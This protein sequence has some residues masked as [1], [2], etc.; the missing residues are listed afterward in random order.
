MPPPCSDTNRWPYP[1]PPPCSDTNFWPYPMPPPMF[2]HQ[3]LALPHATSMFRHQL[4]ALPHA[5]SMFR[6]QLLALPHATS[7]FRHQLLALP[8]ATSMFPGVCTFLK[9]L[10][11]QTVSTCT[12]EQSHS[13]P[14][15]MKAAL[16]SSL[17]T[18]GV[19]GPPWHPCRHHCHCWWFPPPPPLKMPWNGGTCWWIECVDVLSGQS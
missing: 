16:C 14:K 17:G 19:Q 4:L 12:S 13:G 1:L 2:R 3:L 7:M 18:N 10:C 5:T 9:L 8:H 11:T 6:H 15:R